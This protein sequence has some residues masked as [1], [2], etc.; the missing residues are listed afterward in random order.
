MPT[1]TINLD[2]L[3]SL[4]DEVLDFNT[5]QELEANIA[6]FNDEI[7]GLSQTKQK[8]AKLKL[9]DA[10]KAEEKL[11]YL[12]MTPEITAAFNTMNLSGC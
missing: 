5:V 6:I 11:G 4:L 8:Q 1:K 7:S 3:Q 10:A 9:M 12:R 2:D